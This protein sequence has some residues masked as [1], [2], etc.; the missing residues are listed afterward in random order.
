[1]ELGTDNRI[2]LFNK[3]LTSYDGP[4]ADL[5]PGDKILNQVDYFLALLE[6]YILVDKCNN[7]WINKE[8]YSMLV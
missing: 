1:M 3:D 8:I 4:G 5:G 6:F 7:T 2:H